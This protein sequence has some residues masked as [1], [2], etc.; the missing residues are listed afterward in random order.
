MVEAEYMQSDTD[1]KFA[2]L[3]TRSRFLVVLLSERIV[4]GYPF[5]WFGGGKGVCHHSCTHEQSGRF[6]KGISRCGPRLRSDRCTYNRR[7]DSSHRA[8]APVCRPLPDEF[9]KST[10]NRSR[11]TATR[12][13]CI[14]CHDASSRGSSRPLLRQRRASEHGFNNRCPDGVTLTIHA[15][16]LRSVTSVRSVRSLT[17]VSSCITIH[18]GRKSNSTESNSGGACGDPALISRGE[19]RL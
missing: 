19:A 4:R 16:H 5:G 11:W 3:S 14:S 6:S 12:I 1:I 10:R 18:H 9:R 8:I 17:G 7:F 13:Y 2:H 15:K